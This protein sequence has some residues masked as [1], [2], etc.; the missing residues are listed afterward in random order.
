MSKKRKEIN[1][2]DDIN[3]KRCKRNQLTVIDLFAGAGGLSKGFHMA[4]YDVLLAIDNN[5]DALQTYRKN[6]PETTI[7]LGDVR[8]ITPEKLYKYSQIDAAQDI[9]V[10]VAGC[11]CQGF[12]RQNH[13]RDSSDERNSLVVVTAQ[14]IS[15]VKPRAFLLENVPELNLVG[16]EQVTKFERILSSYVTEKWIVNAANFGVPQ[17][18]NRCILVGIRSDLVEDDFEIPIPI[19]THEDPETFLTVRDAFKHLDAPPAD[20]S[21]HRSINN[22]SIPQISPLNQ[23]RLEYVISEFRMTFP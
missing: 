11:P 9:D 6:F 15:K 22:H 12:S 3:R 4:G 17:T 23:K 2:L 19:A 8:Q 1:F 20:G 14:L 13:N 16:I 7:V 10:I 21:N 18:R 5:E